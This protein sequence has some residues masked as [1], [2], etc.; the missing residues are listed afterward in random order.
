MSTIAVNTEK[1]AYINAAVAIS[2]LMLIRI[3]VA[4][5]LK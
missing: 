5:I 2:A 1:S 3:Q 4:G